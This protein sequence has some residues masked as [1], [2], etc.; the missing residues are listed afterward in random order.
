[1]S[2]FTAYYV[3][4]WGKFFQDKELSTP[5]PTFDGRAVCYPAVGNLRDYMSWRQADCEFLSTRVTVFRTR[6]FVHG[7]WASEHH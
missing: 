4:L 1:M 7:T 5:L 6:L 3:H 2:T